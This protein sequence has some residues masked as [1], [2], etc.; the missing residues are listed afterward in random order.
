MAE[1]T[2]DADLAH[3]LEVLTHL[4]WKRESN[5]L[6]DRHGR[7]LVLCRGRGGGREKRGKSNQHMRECSVSGGWGRGRDTIR[8]LGRARYALR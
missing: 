4:F 7:A 8:Q 3:A 5:Q 2:V 6:D 1:T